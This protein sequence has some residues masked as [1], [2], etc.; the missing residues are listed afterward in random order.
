MQWVKMTDRT[1][2][3]DE[4]GRDLPWHDL[5]YTRQKLLPTG[6]LPMSLESA[7]GQD[8]LT[9]AFYPLFLALLYHN[10]FYIVIDQSCHNAART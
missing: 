4:H 9:H 2:N 3:P 6:G 10:G 7:G 1:P 5:L 8:E